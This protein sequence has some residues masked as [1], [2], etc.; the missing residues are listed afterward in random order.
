MP[1]E[2]ELHV[3]DHRANKYQPQELGLCL[4]SESRTL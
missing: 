1:R 4:D 3:E 2:K